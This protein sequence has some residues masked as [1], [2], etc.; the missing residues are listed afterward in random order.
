M[1]VF[2]RPVSKTKRL[3]RL[4]ATMGTLCME[5]VVQQQSYESTIA[6]AAIGFWKAAANSTRLLLRL[7]MLDKLPSEEVG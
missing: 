6:A 3:V 2:L 4:V 1:P 5:N 7:K